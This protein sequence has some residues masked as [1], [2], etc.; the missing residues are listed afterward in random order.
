MGSVAFNFLAR[1]VRKV[2]GEKNW[3]RLQH[4]I[5]SL[6]D[7]DERIQS[8][9]ERRRFEELR[10]NWPPNLDDSLRVLINDRKYL[11][12]PTL[13]NDTDDECPTPK[14]LNE[15][16]HIVYVS[17]KYNDL[18][19]NVALIIDELDKLSQEFKCDILL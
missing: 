10:K 19:N 9:D 12:H 14:R 18:K 6:D 4:D 2:F 5:H 15:I 8:A 1:V 3:R 13:E 17:R 16:C 7:I 11:A